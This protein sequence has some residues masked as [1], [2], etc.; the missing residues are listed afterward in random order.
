[1]FVA[2]FCASMIIK[3]PFQYPKNETSTVIMKQYIFS[4][5]TSKSGILLLPDSQNSIFNFRS[6]LI[7]IDTDY[8]STFCLG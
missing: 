1:M 5:N 2:Y 4:N 3:N 8:I 6:S 7:G